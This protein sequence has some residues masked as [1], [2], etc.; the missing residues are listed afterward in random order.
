MKIT[1][2]LFALI[3]FGIILGLRTY[4]LYRQTGIKSAKPNTTEP[5]AAFINQLIIFC[6][7]LLGAIIIN[8][9]FIPQNYPLL[10]PIPYLEKSW[11]HLTGFGL[12]VCG[13]L[14]SFIAQLQMGHSW[15]LQ[16]NPGEATSLVTNGLFRWSRNPVYL[17][18]GFAFSGFFLMLPNAFSMCFLVLM[19]AAVSVKIRLEEAYLEK[20][21]S[22]AFLRYRS[23]VRRWL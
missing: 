18:L 6:T 1:V 11:L 20:V 17:G 2:I 23:K 10:V 19:Y 21:H 9:L 13:L 8:Y 4:L 15:R 5:I 3:Y 7:F 22:E 12:S 16:H 14:L